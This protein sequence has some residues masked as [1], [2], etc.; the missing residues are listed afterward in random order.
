MVS[1]ELQAKTNAQVAAALPSGEEVVIAVPASAPVPLTPFGLISGVVA[2]VLAKRYYLVLTGT[3]VVV[4]SAR[5][6]CQIVASSPRGATLIASVVPGK[7]TSSVYLTLPGKDKPVTLHVDA[8]WQAEV[9][10]LAAFKAPA[11]EDA[12][13]AASD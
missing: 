8:R 6:P 5:K 10:R 4:L 3:A 11:P 13:Q 2:G 9:D 7:A 12:Q 1:Q